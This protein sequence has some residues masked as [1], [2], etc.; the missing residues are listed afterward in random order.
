VQ[1]F[2]FVP[3]PQSPGGKEVGQEKSRP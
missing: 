3:Q 2:Q 1:I